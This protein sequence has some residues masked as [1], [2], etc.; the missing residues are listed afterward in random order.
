[1]LDVADLKAL[2][3]IITEVLPSALHPPATLQEVTA[4]VNYVLKA[5]DRLPAMPVSSKDAHPL[6]FVIS[7]QKIMGHGPSRTIPIFQGSFAARVQCS[8]FVLAIKPVHFI[9]RSFRFYK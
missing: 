5:T 2:V 7:I 8:I 3:H 4:Y 6:D 1:M 9:K